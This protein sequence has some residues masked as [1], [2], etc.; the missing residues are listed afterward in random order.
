MND[1]KGQIVLTTLIGLLVFLLI[2]FVAVL[3][4]VSTS[5]NTSSATFVGNL[6]GLGASTVTSSFIIPLLLALAGLVTVVVVLFRA[7]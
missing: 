6:S 4:V 2:L 5:I 1:M 7:G 3:P